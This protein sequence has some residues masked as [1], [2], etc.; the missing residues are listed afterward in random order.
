MKS[1]IFNPAKT[2]LLHALSAN[3]YQANKNYT[4]YVFV[5][6]LQLESLGWKDFVFPHLAT[7]TGT[8]CNMEVTVA[9]L[10]CKQA[11]NTSAIMSE[12]AR[13]RL[14]QNFVLHHMI[15]VPHNYF[16]NVRC[17]HLI[18]LL[19]AAVDHEHHMIYLVYENIGINTL[20]DLIHFHGNRN[21]TWKDRIHLVCVA[22]ANGCMCPWAVVV[23]LLPIHL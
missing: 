11:K 1:P 12:L 20:S 18:Q 21:V 2:I 15:I 22:I 13:L 23:K 8:Y 17:S 9:T 5:F 7:C 4:Q 6:V 10:E 14:E 3:M 19:A 16:S